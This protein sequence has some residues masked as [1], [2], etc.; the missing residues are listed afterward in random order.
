MCRI[1][2]STDAYSEPPSWGRKFVVFRG[3]G[4][5]I[6]ASTADPQDAYSMESGGIPNTTYLTDNIGS[7][8]MV[9]TSGYC[10]GS[11]IVNPIN[12]P[13]AKGQPQKYVKCIDV[14]LHDHE[15]SRF[16]GFMGM[17]MHQTEFQTDFGANTGMRFSTRSVEPRACICVL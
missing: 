16:A 2:S 12:G 7:P 4:G 15:A 13:T 17:V 8:L 6:N 14:R 10:T 3:S 9:I 5:Y 1:F 11:N